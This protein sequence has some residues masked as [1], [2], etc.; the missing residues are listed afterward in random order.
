MQN[1]LRPTIPF[2]LLGVFAFTSAYGQDEG[3]YYKNFV[4]HADGTYCEHTEEE[5]SFIAFL[6][7][8]TSR[9]L[10]EN[11][12]RWDGPGDPNI[13]GNGT[14]GVQLDNFAT[15]PPA[16][17][18]TVYVRFTCLA[19]QEQGT[20]FN[21]V[22][23]PWNE[24]PST[25]HLTSA[26]FPAPPDNLELRLEDG[27]RILNWTP[28][29]GVD[30]VV[31][32]RSGADTLDSGQSRSLYY[33]I[34]QVDAPPYTDAAAGDGGFG[35]IVVPIA[36]SV[37]GPHSDEATDIPV[38]PTHV[39]ASQ[40]S[41]EPLAVKVTWDR[42]GN[43][44]GARFAV[45]RSTDQNDP[46][47]LVGGVDSTTFVDS[48][49]KSGQTYW[50]RVRTI[51]TGGAQSGESAPMAVHVRALDVEEGF[52]AAVFA[53][54]GIEHPSGMAWGPD[55]KLYVTEVLS[56]EIKVV[57]D[58]GGDASADHVSVFA[59]GFNM[60]AGVAW[61]GD[62]LYV[63][64][65]GTITI[66]RDDDGDGTADFYDTIISGWEAA[67]HQNNQIVF[68]D[69]GYLLV[70]LGALRDRTTGPTPFHNK[71]LR[72]SPDGSDVQIWAEGIRNVYDMT[73]GPDGNLYG[74]DNGWQD[75]SEGPPVEELN[76]YR[77]GEH[78]GFPEYLGPAP[79]G[80]GTVDPIMTYAPHTS[81]T[82]ITFLTGA[83]IPASYRNDLLLAF[84]GPD[85][86]SRDVLS[87]AYRI[88]RHDL[89]GTTVT[90]T[91]SFAS[92]FYRP[93]DLIQDSTGVLYVADLGNL[94]D[95]WIQGRIYTISY[96]GSS[97]AEGLPP[98]GPTS[99]SIHAYPNPFRRETMLQ[100]RL[101]RPG[102][103]ELEVFDLL[104]RK[105]R[106]LA[107]T[108]LASGRHE[109]AWDGSLE[110]GGRV[111]AGVYACRLRVGDSVATTMVVLSD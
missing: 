41:V 73:F 66:L 71:I 97:A 67:W 89:D 82:G 83:G 76:V 78:Y 61:K 35:Y 8:D 7:E 47:E 37:F 88:I 65:R 106:T 27:A 96:T 59:D 34:G 11:A 75:E 58:H 18:D 49:L 31:Y 19:R 44:Q 15:P 92:N 111:S 52:R 5:A 12:P 90:D 28:Q 87:R 85:Y 16:N 95:E 60:P 50:Y 42:A 64:S 110:G 105:V 55:G 6:N 20:L 70:A 99:V 81:P 36:G 62:S 43:V 25:L 68:D 86:W 17:G 79:A 39:S 74:G 29:D 33:R 38:P 4:K 21:T 54:A 45:Y 23:R 56:G 46:G 32:R 100:F 94:S 2:I 93:V 101:H 109:F 80:S 91:S 107:S 77:Q 104:G 51:G 30:Y 102:R 22:H 57:T 53:D 98:K 26:A 14:F 24:L 48:A 103:V 63:S 40:H 84:Y 72:I 3:L 10:F 108:V 9:V 13:P 1:I 69:E